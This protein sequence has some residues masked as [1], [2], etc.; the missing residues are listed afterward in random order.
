MRK[1][2][3]LGMYAVLALASVSYGDIQTQDLTT[4]AQTGVKAVGAGIMAAVG[5]GYAVLLLFTTLSIIKAYATTTNKV[6]N[7]PTVE[8]PVMEG[9]KSAFIAG[10]P[11]LLIWIIIW[12]V[13]QSYIK[14]LA[15]DSVVGMLISQFAGGGAGQ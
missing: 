7:D 12:I 2:A 9:V 10:L 3:L 1:L 13:T 6:K 5:L 14:P 15:P 4:A 8:N 11:Y